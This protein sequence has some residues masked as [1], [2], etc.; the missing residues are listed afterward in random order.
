[1]LT[2]PIHKLH[3]FPSMYERIAHLPESLL[4]HGDE[5]QARH[6]LKLKN[7]D[8]VWIQEKLDGSNVAVLRLGD[9]VFAVIR[10]GFLASSSRRPMHRLFARWVEHHTALFLALLRPNERLVGEWL[11]LSHG[12]H[13]RLPHGPFVPFDIMNGPIRLP[14]LEFKNRIGP[15]LPLPHLYASTFMQPAQLFAQIGCGQHGSLTVPEG[16]IYR[17]E[18][19][20]ASGQSKVIAIKKWVRPDYLA[21]QYFEDQ[22]ATLSNQLDPKDQALLE[23]LAAQLGLSSFG[24]VLF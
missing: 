23:N 24:G 21:G 8:Q 6:P 11:L 2:P 13:Y 17:Q 22:E 5:R 19:G 9:E 15:L 12:T 3:K 16:F 14:W 10:K 1:M 7:G 4:E 18:R 20:N